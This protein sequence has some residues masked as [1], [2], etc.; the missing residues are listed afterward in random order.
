MTGNNEYR[1]WVDGSY[2]DG[3]IGIGVVIEPHDRRICAGQ[4]GNAAHEA[5]WCAVL[6]ALHCIPEGS[7]VWLHTDALYVLAQL[8]KPDCPV[9]NQ[10]YVLPVRSGEQD[11][12][13]IIAH[14]LATIGRIDAERRG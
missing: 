5:E 13:F 4:R 8:D 12:M 3:W 14:C 9:Y 2:K 7:I 1:V 10:W 6:A 11:S